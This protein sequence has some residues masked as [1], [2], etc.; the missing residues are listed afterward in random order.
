MVLALED[1][2]TE[3]TE[4]LAKVPAATPAAPAPIVVG[5]CCT[6]SGLQARPDLNGRRVT[7]QE[8]QGERWLCS[9][10]DGEVLKVREVNLCADVLE[11]GSSGGLAFSSSNDSSTAERHAMGCQRLYF[12]VFFVAAAK[13]FD[14]PALLASLQVSPPLLPNFLPLS[15]S[16][17]P[18]LCILYYV[19]HTFLFLRSFIPPPRTADRCTWPNPA[20]ASQ[21]VERGGGVAVA[22][23][24]GPRQV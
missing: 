10:D 7:V 9:L 16:F 8:Y 21:A 12:L 11:E 15:T 14:G 23:R 4:A 17:S 1:S 20:G 3:R 2:W 6:L 22:P 19:L 5:A 13:S 24:H 18:L